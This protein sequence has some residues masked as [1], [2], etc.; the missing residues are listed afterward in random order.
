MVIMWGLFEIVS[1]VTKGGNNT[2]NGRVLFRL[3]VRTGLRIMQLMTKEN[4]RD[5]VS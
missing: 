1:I 5:L 4:N 3:H 2:I